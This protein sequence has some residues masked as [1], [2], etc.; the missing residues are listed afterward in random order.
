[1]QTLKNLSKVQNTILLAGHWCKLYCI[2]INNLPETMKILPI[3]INGFPLMADE[4]K[5][6]RFLP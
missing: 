3:S 6:G 4:L 1:M 2:T 5:N